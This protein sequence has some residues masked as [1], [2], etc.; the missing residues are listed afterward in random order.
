MF[1]LIHIPNDDIRR[2]ACEIF[3]QKHTKLIIHRF[4]YFLIIF[5][6]AA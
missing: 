4:Y 2:Q 1:E 6:A 5:V 3:V